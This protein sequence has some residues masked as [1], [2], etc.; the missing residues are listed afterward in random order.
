MNGC[1]AF[2]YVVLLGQLPVSTTYIK[3]AAYLTT[4]LLE[5]L[6]KDRAS[7]EH[8]A[9]VERVLEDLAFDEYR[10]KLITDTVEGLDIGFFDEFVNDLQSDLSIPEADKKAILKGKFAERKMKIIKDFF[11]KTSE[12]GRFLYGRVMTE[13]R[14]CG[15]KIDFTYAFY[16]VDFKLSKKKVEVYNHRNPIYEFFLGADRKIRYEDRSLDRDTQG[17]MT[18]YFRQKCIDGLVEEYPQLT[19][20]TETTTKGDGRVEL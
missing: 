10:E 11:F 13:K 8:M 20:D 3:E 17:H 6:L 2:I 4:K 19:A 15:K 14:E 16:R 9:V 7:K 18:K 12:P 5:S 1:R